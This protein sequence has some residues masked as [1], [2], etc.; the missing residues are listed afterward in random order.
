MMRQEIII[1][2]EK[3]IIFVFNYINP[4]ITFNINDIISFKCYDDYK[5]KLI[6]LM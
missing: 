5:N 2:V 3:I 6:Y 4:L 1:T